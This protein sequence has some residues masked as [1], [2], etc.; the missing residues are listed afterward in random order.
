M[1]ASTQFALAQDKLDDKKHQDNHHVHSALTQDVNFMHS[2]DP[3]EGA[4]DHLIPND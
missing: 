3:S 2:D 4:L 1:V